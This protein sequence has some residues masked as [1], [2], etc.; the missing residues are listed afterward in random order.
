MK[1]K[2]DIWEDT[3]EL[4]DVLY[5]MATC[6]KGTPAAYYLKECAVHMTSLYEHCQKLEAKNDESES[7]AEA[8]SPVDALVSLTITDQTKLTQQAKMFGDGEDGYF[9]QQDTLRSQNNKPENGAVCGQSTAP[10]SVTSPWPAKDI[11][12]KLVEATDILLNDK[13]YDGHGWEQIHIA[14]QKAKRW[15][16]Q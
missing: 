13:D 12:R 3:E 7:N 8:V 4:V 15:L 11:V 14:Q 1:R 16:C 9:M 6:R 5:S 2:L 10:C